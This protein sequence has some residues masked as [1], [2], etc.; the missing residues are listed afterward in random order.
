M[1]ETHTQAEQAVGVTPRIYRPSRFRRALSLVVAALLA[2]PMSLLVEYLATGG[3]DRDFG[4]AALLVVMCPLLL[5]VSVYLVVWVL[6]TR[7]TLWPDRIESRTMTSTRT[8]PLDEIF[9][10]R[11]IQP[12]DMAPQLVLV[13]RG[14]QREYFV[15]G[16]MC[17]FD[18]AFQ[19]WL[20]SIP[21]L[22]AEERRW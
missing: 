15:I 22:D 19:D 6:R 11:S 20:A 14:D 3:A 2:A 8:L 16:N 10:R 7:V 21:D 4:T 13:P 5:L 9:G 17:K 1:I 12:E 18:R